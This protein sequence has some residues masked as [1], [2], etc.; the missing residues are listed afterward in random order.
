MDRGSGKRG[1]EKGR[2][3]MDVIRGTG[4]ATR[5]SARILRGDL[6]GCS[7]SSMS[8]YTKLVIRQMRKTV[9]NKRAAS[10]HQK[11]AGLDS[12]TNNPALCDHDN[13]LHAVRLSRS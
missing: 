3:D 8:D 10:T 12:H 1:D 4:V 2:R 11:H 5:T 9:E 7:T 6:Q 13:I